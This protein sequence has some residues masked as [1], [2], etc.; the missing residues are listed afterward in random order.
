VTRRILPLSVAGSVAALALALAGPLAARAHVTVT[1]DTADPGGYSTLSFRVPNESDTL[2]TVRVE[3]TLPSD[4]PFASVSYQ[5]VPGWSAT[6]QTTTLPEPVTVAGNQLTEAVTHVVWEADAGTSIAP[7]Q[8]QVFPLSLGPVPETG[9]IPL[10]A[11]QTYS[12]GT[13]EEWTGSVD[14]AHPAPVLYVQDAPVSDEH[15]GSTPQAGHDEGTAAAASGTASNAVD[16]L[17]RGLG[18]AALAAGAIALVLASFA[19]VLRRRS[20]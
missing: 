7:G 16:P 13:L 19:L 11:T 12:D 9:S 3:V 6:L 1:P 14:A 4:T 15:S 10:P 8:F 17:A 20:T 5:P 2:G 18:I